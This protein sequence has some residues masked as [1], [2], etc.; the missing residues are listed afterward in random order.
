MV[1]QIVSDTPGAI[2]YVAFS[3]VNKDVQKLKIDNIEP[4]D[5]NVKTNKWIIWSYEHMYTHKNPTSLTTEFIE[6]ILS[7]KVQEEIV[8]KMGY[9][10]VTQMEVKRDWKGNIIK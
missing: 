2:S 8:G 6:Y 9:I 5:E 10:P 4:N 1:R 7:D 3:Y